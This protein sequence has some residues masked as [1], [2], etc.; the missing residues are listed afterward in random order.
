M[1]E[2]TKGDRYYTLDGTLAVGNES[3]MTLDDLNRYLQSLDSRSNLNDFFSI[4]NMWNV[5]SIYNRQNNKNL[6]TYVA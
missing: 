6:M 1:I 4:I 3:R 5:P 2:N